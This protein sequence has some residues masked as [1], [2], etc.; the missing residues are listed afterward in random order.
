[1]VFVASNI[2]LKEVQ[3]N[4]VSNIILEDIGVW[5]LTRLSESRIVAGTNEGLKIIK[6]D[7][8]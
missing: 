6:L 5:K 2:G 8:S 3:K 4:K 7:I 1:M